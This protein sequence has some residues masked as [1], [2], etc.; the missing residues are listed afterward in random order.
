[1]QTVGSFIGLGSTTV[2]LVHDGY[3]LQKAVATSPIRGEFLTDCMLK[4]LEHMHFCKKLAGGT[5]S[6]QQLKDRLEKDLLEESPQTARVRVLACGNA[7]ERR[8]SHE[9]VVTS[10]LI[11]INLVMKLA[12]GTTSIQQLKERLRKINLRSN[13]CVERDG[14]ILIAFPVAALSSSEQHQRGVANGIATM[15]MSLGKAAGL[16]GGKIL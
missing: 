4:S 2:A 8:F 5:T 6:I 13:L 14:T 10:I 3:G 9:Y 15:L 11:F 12:G 16:A 1:M 7:T